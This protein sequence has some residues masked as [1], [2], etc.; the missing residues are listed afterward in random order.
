M[1]ARGWIR[2]PPDDPLAVYQIAGLTA[3][4]T[5]VALTTRALVMT[6]PGVN[7][8]ERPCDSAELRT[9]RDLIDDCER[10]CFAL[11]AHRQEIRSQRHDELDDDRAF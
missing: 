4:E 1:T 9:A 11:D 8:V 10:L 5:A 7:R 3:L 6:Y 2:I